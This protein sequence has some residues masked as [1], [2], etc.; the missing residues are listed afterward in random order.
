M[1]VIYVWVFAARAGDPR[2]TLVALLV[3]AWG[4]RLTFNFARR[5]GYAPGGEDYRWAILRARMPGWRFAV[6]NLGFIAVYQNALL[7]AITL[8]VWTVA[9]HP[10]PLGAADAAAALAFVVL[11]AGETVADQQRWD[12]HRTH[13]AG[14]VLADRPVR[15]QPPS[16]LLLRDR[17]VVGGP[18]LRR[19]RDR[20]PVATDSGRRGRAHRAV[21]RLDG[22]HRADLHPT[23]PGV[24]RLPAQHPHA[25]PVAPPPVRST[26]VSSSAS[27]PGRRPRRRRG[28]RRCVPSARPGSSLPTP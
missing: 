4:V 9:D 14:G 6:F 19:H 20:H 17:P 28:P 12:F 15:L 8:P 18:G 25:R 24:R 2:A 21:P 10:R 26:R 23:A 27:R 16:Q 7:L 11:L 13:P 22:V 1:P 3:S 5:G